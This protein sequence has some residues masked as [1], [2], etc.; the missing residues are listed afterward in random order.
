MI[1]AALRR[2]LARAAFCRTVTKVVSNIGTKSISTGTASIAT[3]PRDRPPIWLSNTELERKNPTN[4]DPQSP[5]KIDAG[6]ELKTRKPSNAPTNTAYE[7]V[8]F[9]LPFIAKFIA[10][11]IAA[12]AEIPA[13]SPS[14]LSSR[15]IAF[16]IPTTQKTVIQISTTS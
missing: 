7:S 16:V 1:A 13:A 5:I 12:I 9:T 8:S 10:S 11:E 4:I 2:R 15:F 14:M 6:L 3:T